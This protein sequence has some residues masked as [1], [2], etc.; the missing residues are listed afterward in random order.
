MSF[1]QTTYAGTWASTAS[2]KSGQLQD[3]RSL[4]GAKNDRRVRSGGTPR[5]KRTR[6][7]CHYDENDNGPDQ[8]DGVPR[9][10]VVEQ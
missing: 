8:H 10:C 9:R 7:H 3:T 2:A 5:G 6:K 4:F 1:P